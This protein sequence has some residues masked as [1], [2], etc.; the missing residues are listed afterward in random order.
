MNVVVKMLEGIKEPNM[1]PN[2]F[3][4]GPAQRKNITTTTGRFVHQGLSV[5]SEL[6][7]VTI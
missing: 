5:I 6:D 4:K 1:P 7:Q 3:A 2:P